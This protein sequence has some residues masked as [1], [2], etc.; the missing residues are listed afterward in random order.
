MVKTSGHP[1]ADADDDDILKK[2]RDFFEGNPSIS[3]TRRMRYLTEM[4]QERNRDNRESNFLEPVSPQD[5][6]TQS[7]PNL[8][9]QQQQHQQQQ[10]VIT[11]VPLEVSDGTMIDAF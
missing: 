7:S 1:L 10:C 4:L 9:I 3:T 11:A 6:M 2:G 5:R 8:R